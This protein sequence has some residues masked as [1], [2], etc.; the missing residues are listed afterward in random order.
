MRRRL[1][2]A[3]VLPLLALGA[4]SSDGGGAG[5]DDDAAPADVLAAAKT[6]LDDTSG[7]HIT[8]STDDLPDGIDGLISA[9]GDGTHAPAFDGTI[10]VRYSGLEPTVPVIAVDGVVYAQVPLTTGWS[11]IDPSEYGAPDPAQLLSTDAGFTSLLPAT[12]DPV[13][14]E[15]VRGGENNAEV[16]TEYTGTVA[17]DTV[18][19]IIPTASGEFDATYTI[20]DG[21]ELREMVLTGDFYGEGSSMTY[22]ITF[23]DYGSEPDISAP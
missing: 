7:V 5:G 8:L 16:L 6:A 17:G 12:E 2:T 13:A 3:A 21:D 10:K 9:D 14:G 15:Q 20:T 18:A 11:E 1:V 19:N 22:T 23:D 4:C